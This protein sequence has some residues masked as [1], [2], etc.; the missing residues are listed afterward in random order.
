MS[1]WIL[2]SRQTEKASPP[3]IISLRTCHSTPRSSSKGISHR[4]S[5]CVIN[6][7]FKW[8][9]LGFRRNL[10]VAEEELRQL[11]G[12]EGERN[13]TRLRFVGYCRDEDAWCWKI[14]RWAFIVLWRMSNCSAKVSVGSPDDVNKALEPFSNCGVVLRLLISV[15]SGETY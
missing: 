10:D 14:C 6:G 12:M 1:L 4:Q 2:V 15:R 7:T 3:S 11:H 5:Q 9:F 8:S 13:L